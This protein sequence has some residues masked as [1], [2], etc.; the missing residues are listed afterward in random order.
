MAFYQVKT[1]NYEGKFIE[2]RTYDARVWR[3]P[4]AAMNTAKRRAAQHAWEGIDAEIV[5]S[6]G[7]VI[8]HELVHRHKS[9]WRRLTDKQCGWQTGE[10]RQR[11]KLF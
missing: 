6:Q 3:G 2:D 10:V 9:K 4:K 5:N 11:P 1:R 8:S 7:V